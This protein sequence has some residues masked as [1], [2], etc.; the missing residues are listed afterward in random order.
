MRAQNEYGPDGHRG[1]CFAALIDNLQAAVGW[2]CLWALCVGDSGRGKPWVGGWQ[3]VAPRVLKVGIFQSCFSMQ[4]FGLDPFWVFVPRTPTRTSKLK[5]LSPFVRF[6]SDV[7][8]SLITLAT[9]TPAQ[10]WCWP[11][12]ALSSPLARQ[13]PWSAKGTSKAFASASLTASRRPGT[14]GNQRSAGTWWWTPVSASS[15]VWGAELLKVKRDQ[16]S[17]MPSFVKVKDVWA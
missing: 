9:L 13:S 11:S 7:F 2:V 5:S 14:T 3:H 16:S 1:L 10:P 8:C 6:F 17:P 15:P 12:K 4:L